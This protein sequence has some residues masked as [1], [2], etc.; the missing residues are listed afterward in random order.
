[1]FGVRLALVFFLDSCKIYVYAGDLCG[2][3]SCDLF[4]VVFAVTDFGLGCL[5]S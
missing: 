3:A 5:S 2:V 1:M 4:S